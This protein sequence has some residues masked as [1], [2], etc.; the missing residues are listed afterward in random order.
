MP[1]KKFGLGKGLG[2]LLPSNVEENTNKDSITIDINLIKPNAN[3]PRK[4]MDESKIRELAASIKEYGIIQPVVLRKLDDTYEIIAGER[5]WR[6][7]MQIGL[8]EIPAV[9]MDV[10]ED[11]ILQISL[12]E[13]IQRDDLNPI[14]EAGAYKKLIEDLNVTQEELSEKLG[15]SRVAI[16]NSM[17]LL[18]LDETIQQYIRDD[19]ISEGH[20]RSLAGIEDKAVQ[21]DYAKKIIKEGLNVRQAENLVKSL[22]EESNEKTERKKTK[23]N[24][25]IYIS[26]II[27]SLENKFGTKISIKD[28]NDRGKIMIEYY[29]KED[30]NR[31]LD[32]INLG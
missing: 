11:K 31:I 18:K 30:L 16:T 17:R 26:E 27:N 23:P 2:A 3:Q 10:S 22:N 9:I 29:T 7:A 14:E 4:S 1:S 15:K 8:R 13:N 5:R 19:L 21:V 6:A 28:N 20:G 32:I 25:D 12:I 24:N